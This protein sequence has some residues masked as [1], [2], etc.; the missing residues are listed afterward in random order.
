M[1]DDAVKVSLNVVHVNTVGVAML[2]LGVV[3]FCVTMAEAVPV[4][5]LPGSVT[6]TV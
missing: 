1:V 5:P 2:A 6:V 3:M 4:Q